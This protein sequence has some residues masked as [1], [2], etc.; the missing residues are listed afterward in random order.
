MNERNGVP[1]S[2]MS[3]QAWQD[4]TT[5]PK[6]GTEILVYVD[7]DTVIGVACFNSYAYRDGGWWGFNWTYEVHEIYPTLWLPIPPRPL[8]PVVGHAG[9]K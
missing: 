7:A 8:P 6:D 9:D 3:E 5:A 1:P 4:I 2:P